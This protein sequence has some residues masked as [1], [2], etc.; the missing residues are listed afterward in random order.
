M[1][2]YDFDHSSFHLNLSFI[3]FACH[4]PPS[5]AGAVHCPASNPRRTP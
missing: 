5:R 4:L 3:T 2:D 1:S